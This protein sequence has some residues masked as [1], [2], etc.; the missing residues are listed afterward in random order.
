[1]TAATD[2]YDRAQTAIDKAG[3]VVR[4]FCAATEG[5][6]D[7]LHNG[8]AGYVAMTTTA[9]LREALGHLE[10]L[11]DLAAAASE[12]APTPWGKA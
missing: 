5:E 3:A 8:D 2:L 6:A 12:P 10:E 1:M 11:R 9:L 4:V 7:L